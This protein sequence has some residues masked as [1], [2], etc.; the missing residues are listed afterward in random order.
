MTMSNTPSLDPSANEFGWPLPKRKQHFED[1]QDGATQHRQLDFMDKAWTLPVLRV[2]IN[3]PKFRLLNGR[4]ASAQQEWLAKHPDKPNDFFRQDPES[5]E[6]QRV[7]HELLGKLVS[8]AGLLTYFKQAENKQKDPIILDCNGFVINGNRRL[9]AWRTLLKEDPQRYGHLAH[10]DVIV[11]PPGDDKAI[12]KLEGELQVEPDIRDD[13]TWDSLANMM[14]IRQELHGLDT[15]ALAEFYKKRESEVKELLDMLDYAA[16]YLEKR[17]K[18]HQWSE[19]SDK[20]FAFRQMVKRREQIGSAG[21][22]RLFEEIAYVL[23]DDSE[24]GRLYEAIPDA[25]KNFEK[26]RDG[27]LD[28]FP[29]SDADAGDGLDILGGASVASPDVPLAQEIG[30]DEAS[31]KRAGGIIRDLIEMLKLLD[32][33]KKSADFLLIQ[34]QKAN[35]FVQNAIT[36]GLRPESRKSGVEEQIAAIDQGLSRIRKWLA[37]NA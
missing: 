14:K 11:L 28:A 7:Q 29:V 37:Q 36:G 26:I 13:Y 16:V 34:L 25:H 21:E 27:L 18:P 31:R 10:I 5:D 24:G 8:G 35:S 12:D 9:C 19:V 30:K 15:K 4:T 3:L 17:G 23:I 33:E 2:P 1:I 20:E 22:K 32:K 6:V